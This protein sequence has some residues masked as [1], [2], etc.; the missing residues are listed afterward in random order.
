MR[1][2]KCIF[3]ILIVHCF[4]LFNFDSFG[5][6]H[7]S[8]KII[9][10]PNVGYA[11]IWNVRA[12]WLK[13]N[14][15]KNQILS[16]DSKTMAHYFLEDVA[17]FEHLNNEIP[18][19]PSDGS[20][21]RVVTYNIHYW[22]D[23]NNVWSRHDIIKTIK[24]IDADILLLQEV[25]LDQ[26]KS[27]PKGLAAFYQQIK[28]IGYS[29]CSFQSADDPTFGNVIALKPQF[30]ILKSAQNKF[31]AHDRKPRSY[32][33]TTIE[34]AN[35]QHI[36]L[37]ATHFEVKNASVSEQQANEL[38]TIINQDTSTYKLIGA[39]FN[40]VRKKD[41][42]YHV[43]GYHLWDDLFNKRVA[44]FNPSTLAV[45]ALENAHF[46][47][48]FDIA[49]KMNGRIGFTVWAGT[50]I[51][52]IYLNPGWNFPVD[53]YVYYSAASDHLPVIV[54]IHLTKKKH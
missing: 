51:D 20:I 42:N 10:S 54:D 39:D 17:K 46:I 23:V 48:A 52:F 22:K 6:S 1:R 18:P 49:K 34:L 12:Q 37:Y 24:N 2:I 3:L 26:T 38:I 47:N 5:N 11:N 8:Q 21:M 45:D 15:S 28:K 50:I 14:I 30:K 25:M 19:K 44:H 9:H 36:S 35:K 29:Y 41:Y 16:I 43:Q 40:A 7:N 4:A 53:L 33:T 27:F 31:A 32:L 13:D